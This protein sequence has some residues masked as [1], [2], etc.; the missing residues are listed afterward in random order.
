MTMPAADYL[1]EVLDYAPD[2]GRFLWKKAIGH[3]AKLG[4]EAG[5]L[6]KS[7]YRIISIHGHEFYAHRLAWRYMTGEN[8]PRV[9]DHVNGDPSDNRWTN[10]RRATQRQNCGNSRVHKN[11]A[12]G[13]KGV[14]FEAS[15]NKWRAQ[16]SRYGKN[17]L[18]GRYASV[19][20]ARSAYA[21][22]ASAVFGEFARAH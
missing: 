17:T 5:S 15:R 4:V 18:I 21:V 11:N 9:I 3:R 2:S 16:I 8:P 20:E 12:I 1:R 22:A 6:R 13:V 7:G 19:E 14:S 10:L